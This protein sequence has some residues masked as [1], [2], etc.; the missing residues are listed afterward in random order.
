MCDLKVS[1]LARDLRRL[2]D[3]VE[4]RLWVASPYIGS[5]KAV[6]RILGSARADDQSGTEPL[7]VLQAE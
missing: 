1:E 2:A 7:G 3:C 5:W 6:R 4:C